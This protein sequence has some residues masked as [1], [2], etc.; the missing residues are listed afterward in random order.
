MP[1]FC[2]WSRNRSSDYRSSLVA[3]TDNGLQAPEPAGG[4]ARVKSAKSNRRRVRQLAHPPEGAQPLLNAPDI[5]TSRDGAT[6]RYHRVPPGCALRPSAVAALAEG[7]CSGG[8]TPE[9]TGA[10][11]RGNAADASVW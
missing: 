6:L 9:A 8:F 7:R 11:R 1:D 4:V 5:T 3:A 10:A 2:L